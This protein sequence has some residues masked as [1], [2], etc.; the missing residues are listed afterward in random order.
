MFD[1][2]T[3]LA[4]IVLDNPASARVFQRHGIDFCCRGEQTLGAACAAKGLVPEVVVEE[5]ARVLVGP[6]PI[7]DPRGWSNAALVAHIVDQH[8]A[9]LREQLPV[10]L[11]LAAKVKRVHGARDARLIEVDSI[12]RDLESAL[13]P[14]LDAEEESLF[15]RL[16][17]DR[18]DR[19]RIAAELATMLEDHL[20]VGALLQRLRL[21]TEGFRLPDWAC[22]SFRVLFSELESLEGDVLTHVHLENHVLMPRFAEEA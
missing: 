12:V 21:V 8:H 14:H 13:L 11:E 19:A 4:R 17:D 6:T 7:E 5:L 10:L 1:T 18:P 9:Y 3:T 16:L 2:R 20:E 22:N 15:P